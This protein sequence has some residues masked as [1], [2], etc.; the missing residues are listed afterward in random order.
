MFPSAYLIA[1]SVL[2]SICAVKAASG[3]TTFNDYGT[4]S[5]VACGSGYKPTNSQGNGI[6]AA[7]PNVKDLE[8]LA[9]ATVTVAATTVL[10]QHAQARVP[11]ENATTS[12]VGVMQSHFASLLKMI[13]KGTGS[14]D[15]ETS[16]KCSGKTIKVKVVDACPSTHPENYCKIKAFGGSIP[17]YGACEASGTNAFDIATTARGALS[18]YLGAEV[19]EQPSR[20][21]WYCAS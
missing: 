8:M 13:F 5:G 21:Y 9:S 11:V 10:D 19:W 17:D 3:I 6:Y 20:L 15:G 4:Q 18:S 7:D 1:V 2:A 14:L 16:G 12:N